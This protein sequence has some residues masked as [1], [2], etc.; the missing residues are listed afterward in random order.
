MRRKP[1]A[2]LLTAALVLSAASMACAQDR[3]PGPGPRPDFAAMQAR[4]E[5]HQRQRADDLRTILRLRPDQEPALAAFLQAG[6]KVP[7]G[8]RPPPAA[9]APLTTPQRLDEMARREAQHA[10][11]RDARLQAVKAFYAALSPDQRAV[12]DALQRMHGPGHGF[13]G[14]PPGFGG[15]GG[16]PGP[17][18]GAPWD[19]PAPR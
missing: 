3:G 2:I 17:G 8:P 9:E 7:P 11:A 15:P 19:G 10:Q 6:P 4:R 5:A 18:H 13:G 12:F 14:R 16:R 1:S